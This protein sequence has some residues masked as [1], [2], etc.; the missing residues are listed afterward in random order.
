MGVMKTIPENKGR[1]SRPIALILAGYGSAFSSHRGLARE[2]RR[3]YGRGELYRGRNKFLVTLEGQP[4]IR[5]LLDAVTGAKRS[6]KPLYEKIVIYNDV[7]SFTSHVD[8]A[9]YPR[10]SVRQM[11]SSVAGHLRD[12]LPSV[13]KGQRVDIYFGDTPRVTS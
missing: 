2:I 6:R 11:T 3:A 13:K 8:A 9:L 7:E 10:V 1:C 4:V 5:Y 12:F